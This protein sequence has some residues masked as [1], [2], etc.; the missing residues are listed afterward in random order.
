MGASEHTAEVALAL[1][2]AIIQ[3]PYGIREKENSLQKGKKESAS[4]IATDSFS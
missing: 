1:F 2:A 3:S 4:R